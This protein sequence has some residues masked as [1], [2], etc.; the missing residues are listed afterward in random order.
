MAW[1]SFMGAVMAVAYFTL[2]GVIHFQESWFLKSWFSR[3]ELLK[4]LLLKKLKINHSIL[5]IILKLHPTPYSTIIFTYIRILAYWVPFI[6]L[7]WKEFFRQNL[8]T[9]WC[10]RRRCHQLWNDL[11]MFPCIRYEWRGLISKHERSHQVVR[12]YEDEIYFRNILVIYCCL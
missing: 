9:L 2:F 1:V 7:A 10:C 8:I 5:C 11:R 4:D 6:N 12:R 3:I